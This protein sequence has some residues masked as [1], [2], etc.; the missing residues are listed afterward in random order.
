MSKDLAG[1]E[2]SIDLIILFL[3]VVAIA[4]LV[5][6]LGAMVTTAEAMEADPA[7]VQVSNSN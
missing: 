7:Y 6:I 1:K 4:V 3:N 2:R 5:G